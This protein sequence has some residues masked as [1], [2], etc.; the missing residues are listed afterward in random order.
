MSHIKIQPEAPTNMLCDVQQKSLLMKLRYFNIQKDRRIL[1]TAVVSAEGAFMGLPIV[2][3]DTWDQQFTNTFNS[4]VQEYIDEHIPGELSVLPSSCC[5]IATLAMGLIRCIAWS[6]FRLE[7]RMSA[8]LQCL[9]ALF[10]ACVQIGRYH[11]MFGSNSCWLAGPRG[12]TPAFPAFLV[13][14]CDPLLGSQAIVWQQSSSG[15][16]GR[17]QHPLT[18]VCLHA[19]HSL[20][21]RR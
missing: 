9:C 16:Q 8:A 20:T 3:Q 14:R 15:R 11:G 6:F 13:M 2:Q 19:Q 4:A 21:C 5:P 7:G 12:P 1:N 18:S 10:L 17:D